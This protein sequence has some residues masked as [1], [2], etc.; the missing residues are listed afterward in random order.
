MRDSLRIS[1][2]QVTAPLRA[3]FDV[4]QPLAIRCF[5]V[6]ERS[7]RGKIC[8]DSLTKSTWGAVQYTSVSFGAT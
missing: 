8:M 3:L 2:H 6:L 5:A 1:A 7:I 4:G